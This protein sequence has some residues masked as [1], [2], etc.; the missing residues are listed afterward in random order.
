KA[1]TLLSRLDARR[2][3]EDREA[4]EAIGAWGA[5]TGSFSY[6]LGLGLLFTRAGRQAL[7]REGDY[8]KAEG[9]FRLAA[10]LNRALGARCRE[11]QTQA[12]LAALHHA[13][14]NRQRSQAYLEDAIDVLM[15]VGDAPRS[16]LGL[17]RQR[18]A[19]LVQQV[20]REALDHRDA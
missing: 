15:R 1:H 7:L 11:S 3:P 18:A 2:F 10:A 19:L 20:Y 8:E 5:G 16:L 17:V 12:D 6:A 13:V 9:C 4:A 14:G